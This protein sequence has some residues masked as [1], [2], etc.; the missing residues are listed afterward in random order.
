MHYLENIPSVL[1]MKS[2]SQGSQC[3]IIYPSNTHLFIN[4]RIDNLL[5]LNTRAQGQDLNPEPE[6][7]QDAVPMDQEPARL[8]FS[9]IEPPQAEGP[10]KSQSQNISTGSI[11]MVP[12]EEF[13]ELPNGGREGGPMNFMSLKSS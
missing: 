11:M 13:L 3:C 7:L 8:H 5:P 6:F 1:P 4:V 12:E 10:A 9:E 2:I